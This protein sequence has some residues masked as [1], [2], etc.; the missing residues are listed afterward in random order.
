LCVFTF[1]SV[2]VHEVFLRR[3]LAAMEK[4]RLRL[5]PAKCEVF[6]THWHFLGHVIS[7]EGMSQSAN[8]LQAILNWPM[9]TDLKSVRSFASL[10]SY[11]RKFVKDFAQIE[12]PLTDLLRADGWKKPF[13]PEVLEAFE[14]LKVAL[15]T[16]P[17]LKFFDVHAESTLSVDA[18]GYSIGD[19]L[20]QT[21]AD[22]NV[23]PVGFCSRRLTDEEMKYNTYDRELVGLWEEVLH[24]R[25][26]LLGIPFKVKTDHCSLRWLLSQP[27]LT[28]QRQRWL[29]VLQESRITEI[30]HV[31]G[32]F[33]VVADVL[34]RYPDPQE[35]SYDH[36]IPENSNMDVRFSNLVAIVNHMH[37]G[38]E[39]EAGAE[40]PCTAD[41][42]SIYVD[43]RAMATQ[44][45]RRRR[46][47]QE[48]R[49]MLREADGDIE[50][51]RQAAASARSLP[52]EQ[53]KIPGVEYGDTTTHQSYL[54]SPMNS[55][56]SCNFCGSST[57]D[58]LK[59]EFFNDTA[60][61]QS[62][63]KISRRTGS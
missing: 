48:F 30:I 10:F 38:T 60:C 41:T 59:T 31:A 61:N 49:R 2:E 34:S 12:R 23:R 63:L 24:F 15:T 13:A 26:W 8:K 39:S 36:L 35:Q 29:T 32:V 19:V 47:S 42:G 1:G 18:S 21:D 55:C 27:E 54:P 56:N 57:C 20:H 7:N 3:V 11:Y 37:S 45:V 6:R 25:H 58:T 33:N 16:S 50:R 46:D 43:L 22:G 17:V 40:V 4:C 28:G 62:H 14:N 51:L 5:Q 52:D 9:L 53:L 44:T